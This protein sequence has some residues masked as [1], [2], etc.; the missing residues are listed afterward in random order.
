MFQLAVSSLR[1]EVHLFVK[2]WP[3]TVCAPGYSLVPSSQM[4]PSLALRQAANKLPTLME[5]IDRSALPRLGNLLITPENTT[6][7]ESPAG[8]KAVDVA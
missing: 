7:E 5:F 8:A 6:V 1:S 2:S 4:N 3:V